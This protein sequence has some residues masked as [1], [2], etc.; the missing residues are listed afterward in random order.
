[1]KFMVS[2]QEKPHNYPLYS[3]HLDLESFILY[4]DE[5]INTQ[6]IKEETKISKTNPNQ[7]QALE[8]NTLPETLWNM[9]F[10]GSCRK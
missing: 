6:V 10:N 5:D 2:S 3:V 9:R 4:N 1:M 8:Q 7:T